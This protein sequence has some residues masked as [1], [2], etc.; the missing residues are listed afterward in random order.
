[1]CSLGIMGTIEPAQ[2]DDD[3]ESTR[4]L[5]AAARGD[6]ALLGALLAQHREWLR[7]MVALRMDRRLQG[8]L[9]PSDVI[10]DA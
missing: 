9:D 5:E 1:M 6:R 2:R 8:R 4:R 3:G 7:R 10:Q